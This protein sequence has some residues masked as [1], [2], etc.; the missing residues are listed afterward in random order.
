MGALNFYDR[1]AQEQEK[2][3]LALKNQEAKLE[4]LFERWQELEDK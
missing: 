4:R 2:T 3:L 1:P